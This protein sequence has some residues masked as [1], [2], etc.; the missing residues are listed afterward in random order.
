MLMLIVFD[1]TSR[2]VCFYII[3]NNVVEYF[4]IIIRI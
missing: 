4:V 1:K 3:F 2:E